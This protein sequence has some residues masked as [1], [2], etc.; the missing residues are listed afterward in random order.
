MTDADMKLLFVFS[1]IS[2]VFV[3]LYQS[4]KHMKKSV[5]L[6]NAASVTMASASNDIAK[7]R[8]ELEKL[9]RML[10]ETDQ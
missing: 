2:V 1:I 3:L 8:E 4:D 7:L 6:M 9:R 10:K 5:D